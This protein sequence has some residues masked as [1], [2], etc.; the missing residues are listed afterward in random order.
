[1]PGERLE[2][3]RYRYRWILSPLR[4]PFRHPGFGRES[5]HYK[6]FPALGK[7]VKTVS[8]PWMHGEAEISP[9]DQAESARFR[10]DAP[11]AQDRE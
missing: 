4:L 5:G 9:V 1:M 2:L 6:D 11:L 3:S 10:Y 8:K 7:G